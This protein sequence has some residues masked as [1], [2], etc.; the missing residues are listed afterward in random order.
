MAARAG[1]EPTTL[2]L[3]VNQGATMSHIMPSCVKD[4]VR[5]REEGSRGGVR[6]AGA[7]NG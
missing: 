2:R 4:G 6:A 5:R 1:V 3:K 7:G